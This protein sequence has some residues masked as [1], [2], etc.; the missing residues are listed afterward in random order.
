MIP[1]NTVDTPSNIYIGVDSTH[2][3]LYTMVPRNTVDTPSNIYIGVDST[4]THDEQTGQLYVA[5]ATFS[6]RLMHI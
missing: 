3:V 1:R 6:S 2:L 4:H 5:K